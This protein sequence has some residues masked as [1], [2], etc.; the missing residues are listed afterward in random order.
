M[1]RLVCLLVM[2]CLAL[3]ACGGSEARA[4]DEHV[5]ALAAAEAERDL[6]VG[7][8]PK[9]VHAGVGRF[10]DAQATRAAHY[11]HPFL[12]AAHAEPCS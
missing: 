10:D 4:P 1:P 9:A 8:R 12:E 2:G 3:G 7:A 11:A 5:R 6:A